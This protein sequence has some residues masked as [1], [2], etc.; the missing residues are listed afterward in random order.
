MR[1]EGSFAD[2]VNFHRQLAMRVVR[3]PVAH[4]ILAQH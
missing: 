4:G 3:S 2:D 1:G